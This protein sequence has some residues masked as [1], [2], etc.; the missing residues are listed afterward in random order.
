[1]AGSENVVIDNIFLFLFQNMLTVCHVRYQWN[2]HEIL[3]CFIAG[4]GIPSLQIQYE[5]LRKIVKTLKTLALNLAQ[6]KIAVLYMLT[7][8]TIFITTDCCISHLI[9]ILINDRHNIA[10]LPELSSMVD[11]VSR[12]N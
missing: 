9:I 1:M 7:I 8:I 10:L 2:C 4:I 11:D 5:I 12:H 3:G 6:R